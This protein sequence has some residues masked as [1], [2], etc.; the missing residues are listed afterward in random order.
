MLSTA[1]GFT[2]ETKP[3][4]SEGERVLIFYFMGEMHIFTGNYFHEC[5]LDNIFIFYGYSIVAFLYNSWMSYNFVDRQN[6]EWLTVHGKKPT[7]T[8][9][10][11]VFWYFPCQFFFSFFLFFF[12]LGVYFFWWIGKES[13]RYLSR[14]L[15]VRIAMDSVSR[16]NLSITSQTEVW[17]TV[18][19]VHLNRI[20]LI[21]YW[22]MR[23]SRLF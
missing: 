23:W 19:W 13:M 10:L 16:L 15:L 8:N 12:Y 9:C 14:Q 4:L 11:I 21:F 18:L 7:F 20:P 5:F 22:P 1:V 2:V 3:N 6:F 17:S